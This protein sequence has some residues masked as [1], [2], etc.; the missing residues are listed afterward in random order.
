M[1]S[2]YISLK[3]RAYLQ[4]VSKLNSQSENIWQSKISLDEM[5]REVVNTS[6]NKIIA[7]VEVETLVN[8]NIVTWR[9]KLKIV[10]WIDAA[11]SRQR[12]GKHTASATN[13]RATMGKPSSTLYVPRLYNE[14]QS[15]RHWLN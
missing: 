3:K 15:L 6:R 1:S 13:E 7:D 9:L 5:K 10:E 14:D 11:I 4:E 8:E 12:R 2:V